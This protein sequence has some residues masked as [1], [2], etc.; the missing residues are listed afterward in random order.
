M[1]QAERDADDGQAAC[2]AETQMEQGDL[3]PS[4]KYP[5]DVHPDSETSGIIRS[6]GHFMSERPECEPCYLEQLQS[7]RDA[8]D[9]DAEQQS[10]HSIVEAYYDASKEEPEYVTDEFHFQNRCLVMSKTA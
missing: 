8:D 7:E 1:L 6:G 9:G 2:D 5:D 3:D 4:A 10:H